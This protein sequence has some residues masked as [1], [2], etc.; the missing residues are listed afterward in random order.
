[1]I[2]GN[3]LRKSKES[4]EGWRSDW[5]LPGSWASW[6]CS[7]SQATKACCQLF[8]ARIPVM[9]IAHHIAKGHTSRV[10]TPQTKLAARLPHIRSQYRMT[11]L[12][13]GFESLSIGTVTFALCCCPAATSSFGSASVDISAVGCLLRCLLAFQSCSRPQARIAESINA[14]QKCA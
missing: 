1:M 2:Q 14:A 11:F 13:H 10:Y 4:A 8:I 6:P 7:K 3:I 12:V 9:L 5:S